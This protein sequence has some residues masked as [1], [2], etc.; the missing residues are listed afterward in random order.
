MTLAPPSSQYWCM[1]NRADPIARQLADRHYNRQKIGSLQF[2]PPGSCVVFVTECGRAFWVTSVPFAQFVKHA[3]AGAWICSAFRSEGAGRA[4]DLIRQAV[5]A[6]KAH[7]GEPPPL[8]MVTFVNREKVRPTMVRGAPVWGWT[9]RKA[10]FVEAGETK[11]GL[12]ALQLL[13][14]DMPA[15]VP[16]RAR[17]LLGLPLFT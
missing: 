6:T 9:F 8:G 3:W 17:P 14:A 16:A 12:L 7:Y 5:A 10:G 2:V 15:P 4:S 1:S 13:P 11:G